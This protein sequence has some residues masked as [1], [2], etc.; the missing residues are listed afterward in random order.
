MSDDNYVWIRKKNKYERIFFIKIDKPPYYIGN[1]ETDI[2]NF[3]PIN[4]D[5]TEWVGNNDNKEIKLFFL[6]NDTKRT[7]LNIKTRNLFYDFLDNLSLGYLFVNNTQMTNF[8]CVVCDENTIDQINY[9]LKP[10][11]S[12]LKMC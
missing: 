11:Y 10:F 6:N 3:R 1:S 2:L 5:N 4:N 9:K 8:L 7:K 12:R